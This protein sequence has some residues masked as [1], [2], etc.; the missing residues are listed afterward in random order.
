MTPIKKKFRIRGLSKPNS[1]TLEHNGNLFWAESVLTESK[2]DQ[3]FKYF[4]HDWDD[5]KYAVLEY[6]EQSDNG[7]P[8]NA[9]MT[10]VSLNNLGA[11]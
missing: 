11:L 7:T 5:P 8:I 9:L 4:K 10:E 6:T 2:F 3:L 1:V